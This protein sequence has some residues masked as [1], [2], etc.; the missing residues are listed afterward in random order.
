MALIKCPECGKEIS[1]YAPACIGC[2]CPMTRIQ[3]I[4]SKASAVKVE[5]K[6]EKPSGFLNKLPN[7]EASLIE[8]IKSYL[9]NTFPKVFIFAEPKHYFGIKVAG[10][11]FFRFRF[12]K[13]KS[14]LIFNY[15][16]GKNMQSIEIK[17]HSTDQTTLAYI[18][19][20][21]KDNYLD[22]QPKT[23]ER[24]S[25]LNNEKHAGFLA[26]LPED[27]QHIV[28]LFDDGLSNKIKPLEIKDNKNK[29]TYLAG[30]KKKTII[31]WFTFKRKTLYLK[32]YLH[33]GRTRETAIKKLSFLDIEPV[34]TAIAE[35]YSRQTSK[36]NII[37]QSKW[38]DS[39]NLQEKKVISNFVTQFLSF[40]KNY[41]K[42]ETETNVELLCIKNE[43]LP[44]FT[45]ESIRNNIVFSFT[46][47]GYLK[48]DSEIDYRKT[49]DLLYFANGLIE[50]KTIVDLREHLKRK[51]TID[52]KPSGIYAFI[53]S[54]SASI[55][56]ED[57]KKIKEFDTL[58]LEK[59]AN[60]KIE[61]TVAAY[62]YRVEDKGFY[63]FWFTK[64]LNKVVFKY[65]TNVDS[66]SDTDFSIVDLK[67][68]TPEDL[69]RIVDYLL[70][71]S[72]KPPKKKRQLLP[73]NNLIISAMKGRKIKDGEKYK[74]LAEDIVE[75]TTSFIYNTA[76]QLKL[77]TTR[78]E[79]DR[80]KNKYSS[81]NYHNHKI[82][83]KTIGDSDASF[84]FRYYIAARL[85][86]VIQKYENVMKETIIVNHNVVLDELYRLIKN[87]DNG[88]DYIKGINSNIGD[89]PIDEFE[90]EAEKFYI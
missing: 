58:I 87:D 32:Y 63:A 84:C 79:F 46:A 55:S 15:C 31:C 47:N 73:I 57:K 9:S 19:K 80:Y 5:V 70:D 85:M 89:V 50:G 52:T 20:I 62:C 30:A 81:Y 67:D 38:T 22:E 42:F 51:E 48:R 43:L 88:Y 40:N 8:S 74:E 61:N 1:E 28:E 17:V 45:F 56:A 72:I 10:E 78:E 36:T 41:Q 82:S 39:L 68:H 60:I 49:K 44:I 4:L 26:S 64:N 27:K 66:K 76:K 29:R 23:N 13:P 33:P 90:K 54:F 83:F 37:K 6:G 16:F 35:M 59:Y 75:Y 12:T 2:G 3:E 25:Y 65:R 24:P 11:D 21:I 34:T 77:F 86:S 14:T 53:S 18:L 7:N 69:M 71:N